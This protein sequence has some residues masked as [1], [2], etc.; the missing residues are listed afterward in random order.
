MALKKQKT[1]D[2]GVMA[3]YW[4]AE[5]KNNMVTKKTDIILLAYKNEETRKNN[6]NYLLRERYLPLDGVYKTG[7]EVYA[8]IKQ[9]DTIL[10]DEGNEVEMNFF[11]DAED[12]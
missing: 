2:T 5:S 8:F 6:N 3:E 11:A 9:S 1:L 12:C 4:V 10:D 7:E